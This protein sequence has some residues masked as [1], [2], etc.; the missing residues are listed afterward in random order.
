MTPNKIVS[1]A[2]ATRRKLTLG[3]HLENLYQAGGF[4]ELGVDDE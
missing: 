3:H 4:N 1:L 2:D